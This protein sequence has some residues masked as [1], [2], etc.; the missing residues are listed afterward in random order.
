MNPICTIVTDE[1]MGGDEGVMEG[2]R[3]EQPAEKD[4]FLNTQLVTRCAH[5]DHPE[6]LINTIY[7]TH[8][9][10]GTFDH[11]CTCKCRHLE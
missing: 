11:K 3:R 10:V 8:N 2:K 1:H 6:C 9:T 7:N 4:D 5:K